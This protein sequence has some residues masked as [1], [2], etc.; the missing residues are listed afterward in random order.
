MCALTLRISSVE[1]IL[2]PIESES[3]EKLH[4]FGLDGQLDSPSS[5]R[6]NL[7]ALRGLNYLEFFK[8]S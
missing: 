6:S 2:C 7:T 8:F 5:A 4:N 1:R 3:F